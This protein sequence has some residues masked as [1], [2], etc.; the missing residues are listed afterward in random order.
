MTHFLT[1]V[2]GVLKPQRTPAVFYRCTFRSTSGVTRT[3]KNQL[4]D[5]LPEKVW[6]SIT[7]AGKDRRKL[8]AYH[9]EMVDDE[10]K[11]KLLS[12]P[13]AEWLSDAMLAR[14]ALEAP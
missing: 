6:R 4:R 5:A 14:I 1:I 3:F 9:V 2:H 13:E 8:R 10:G 7:R 11:A 12:F